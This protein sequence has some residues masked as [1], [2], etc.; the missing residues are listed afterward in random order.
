MNRS[1]RRVTAVFVAILATTSLT[2]CFPLLVGGAALGSAV[3]FTD[4]RTSG[5]QLEDQ[6]IELK[7]YNRLREATGDRAKLSVNSFNQLVL[8]TGETT[9]EAD[10]ALAEQT[11]SKIE[12][13]RSTVNEATVA[14]A[15]TSQSLGSDSILTGKVKAAIVDTKDLQVN[16]FKVVTDRGTVYLMGRVTEREAARAAEVTRQVSGVKKVVR[17]FEVVTEAELAELQPKP[18][19]K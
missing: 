18:T 11:V 6:S 1:A 15:L 16:A 9:S 10:K 8:I 5:S 13:V 4:R 7:A 14:S 2:G 17:V 12:N 19:P 3:V